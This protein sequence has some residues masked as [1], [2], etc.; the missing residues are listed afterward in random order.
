MGEPVEDRSDATAR[1]SAR[2]AWLEQRAIIDGAKGLRDDY[3]KNVRN[4]EYHL[5]QAHDHTEKALELQALTEPVR[6]AISEIRK[7]QE[8]LTQEMTDNRMSPVFVFKPKSVEEAEKVTERLKE[9]ER[10]HSVLEEATAIMEK[11]ISYKENEEEDLLRKGA[12]SRS[13]YETGVIGTKAALY[14]ASS[15]FR[16]N[17]VAYKQAAVEDAQAA[18]V[19]VN[20]PP[21]TDPSPQPETQAQPDVAPPTPES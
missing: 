19:E 8:R 2:A 11:Q 3:R 12:E 15:H 16:D 14:D 7:A 1:D 17:E 21:Y 5:G 9:Y 10:Q 4:E 13:K 20:Y 6:A 18:G